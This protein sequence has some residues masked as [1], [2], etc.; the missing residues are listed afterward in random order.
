[1]ARSGPD[2]SSVSFCDPTKCLAANICCPAVRLGSWSASTAIVAVVSGHFDVVV[3]PPVPV[4]PL[5]LDDV[6]AVPPVPLLLDVVAAPPV[7][8]APVPP[9]PLPP[10]AAA[11]ERKR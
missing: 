6:V 5:L 7:W 4:V 8:V 2:W 10:H 11:L 9:E 1:M 3:P